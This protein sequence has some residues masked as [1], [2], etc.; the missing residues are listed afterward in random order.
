MSDN[1]K[2][3]MAPMEGVTG[4]I[5]RNTFARFFGGIDKY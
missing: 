5:Y 3:Y 1:K 2:I 4:F